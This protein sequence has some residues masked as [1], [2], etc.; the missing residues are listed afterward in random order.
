MRICVLF[1]L[2]FNLGQTKK[3]TKIVL[4]NNLGKT[5]KKHLYIVYKFYHWQQKTN[6]NMLKNVL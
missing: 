4:I 5:Q 3:Q 6:S 2:I 1:I